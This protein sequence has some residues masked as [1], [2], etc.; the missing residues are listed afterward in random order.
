MNKKYGL[1]LL[2]V[3]LTTS[4][5]FGSATTN[6]AES[7]S[8]VKVSSD[9]DLYNGTRFRMPLDDYF[10]DQDQM[11]DLEI[12]VDKLAGACM[13][14]LGR[15]WPAKPEKSANIPWNS[16]R[17]GVTD[18]NSARRYGYKAPLPAGMSAKQATELDKKAN[19]RLD[20]V[21]RR[22][23]AIYT[24]EDSAKITGV[25]VPAGG[26]RG[27]AYRKLG[28]PGPD[29]PFQTRVTVLQKRIWDDALK[30]GPVLYAQNK[31]RD[32]MKAKGYPYKN[33]VEALEDPKWSAPG[34]KSSVAASS[35]TAAPQETATAVDDVECKKKSLYAETWHTVEVALQKRAIRQNAKPLKAAAA[36]ARA[37]LAKIDSEIR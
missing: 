11:G 33:P 27:E 13:N 36:Q 2:V 24:G 4:C 18:L 37:A 6:R 20:H 19:H 22:T 25:E 9:P 5:T 34:T 28:L 35:Y 15:K 3:L 31:W 30:T 23:I 10:F 7:T 8:R 29:L 26:C 21:S 1:A 16:R 17:Y 14:R 12:A 32:C